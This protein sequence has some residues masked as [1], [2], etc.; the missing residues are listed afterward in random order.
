MECSGSTTQLEVNSQSEAVEFDNSMQLELSPLKDN[1]KCVEEA[2]VKAIET[3]P[4][5]CT[6]QITDADKDFTGLKSSCSEDNQ[7]LVNESAHQMLQITPLMTPGINGE[8]FRNGILKRTPRGCRGICNCLNCT[9][10]RLHAERSFEF[11]RNQMHDAEEVA[12]DLIND[13]TS[14]RKL[15]E[16]TAS[17]SNSLATDKEKQVFF[18]YSS[19]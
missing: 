17:D 19:I 6:E 14:L 8:N 16:T 2:T 18:F 5:I 12:L 13:L 1:L 11:S 15:L 10:F 7:E 4:N 3:V 9:S